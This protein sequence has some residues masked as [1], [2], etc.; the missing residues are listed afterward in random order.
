[1]IDSFNENEN[2]FERN[3]QQNNEIIYQNILNHKLNNQFDEEFHNTTTIVCQN[4]IQLLL[5]PHP[6]TRITIH[7]LL[8]HHWFSEL[9]ISSQSSQSS[10]SSLNS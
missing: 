9:S 7:Q 3:N 1:M 10:Q 8:Q 6:S 2:N 5:D 4:L